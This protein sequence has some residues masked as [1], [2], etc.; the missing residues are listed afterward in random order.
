MLSDF[1]FQNP[2]PE[3]RLPVI[4]GGGLTGL[5]I[6]RQ[7]SAAGIE[8]A[9]VCAPPG[10]KPRLG[11]SLNAEGSL[12]AARQFPEFSRFFHDKQRIAL[13]FGD[14]AVSFD[15]IRNDMA[16]AWYAAPGFPGDVR[17]VHV[18]RIGF[19]QAL[20]DDVIANPC[21]IWLDDRVV[22]VDARPG[23]ERI[24]Q[25]RLASGRVL[26][27]SYVFDAT[28][29]LSVVPRSLGLAQRI[30]GEPRRVVFAH[31]AHDAQ[32]APRVAPPWL[33]AT[34]LLRLQARRD[35]VDG[36]A[37][38]I[39]LGDYVSIGIGV[40]P[41]TT[42]ANAQ[43]LLQWTERAYAARGIAVRESFS[44]RTAPIDLSYRHYDHDRCHGANWLLAG[45]TC[46]QVW[47]PS[48]AGVGSGLLAAR[49]APD[50]LH[51]PR[52]AGA[53]YQDYMVDVSRS[54]GRLDWLAHA[55]PAQLSLADVRR[56][57]T[58]MARGNARRLAGYVGLECAPRELDF[59]NALL[60]WFEA[61]RRTASPVSTRQLPPS[62]Q[63]GH[64]FAQAYDMDPWTDPLVQ[65]RLP[66]AGLPAGAPKAIA[67]LV[68]LL[69]GRQD[70]AQVAAILTD[71]VELQ[72][73]E[74]RLVGIP[75]FEAWLARMREAPSVQDVQLRV[76]DMTRDGD[77][78]RLAA[79][80]SGTRA[81]SPV[82]SG[83][84]GLRAALR[85]DLV[86]RLAVSRESLTL[87]AGEGSLPRAAF[88]TL[89]QMITAP[90]A[91]SR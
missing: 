78:W 11:E 7:L 9:L 42:S 28:N 57:A 31:Y 50:L 72:L 2:L 3:E 75:A 27:A 61:A 56:R 14:N 59:G 26:P 83:A 84:V 54:H 46:C 17:L 35:G 90:K 53:I 52:R 30:I 13:F 67:A 34:T 23:G 68:D 16:P 89:M 91:Q 71:D 49:L 45:S 48:A 25:V 37:W 88:A 55:D 8:H 33:R 77:E 1:E 60:R 4:L 10:N 85:G 76:R 81:K 73:D 40:D 20:Y 29:H 36:L 5:A 15:A 44:A 70:D 24:H 41:A 74:F 12:E 38:C 43:L 21:C 63:S 82:L 6:S 64:L 66:A 58:T 86:A 62:A 47:F 69:S 32:A 18:E 80:W 87:M 19:D 65:A 51:A 39:P 79:V 22:A